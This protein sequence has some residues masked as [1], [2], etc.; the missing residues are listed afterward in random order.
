MDNKAKKKNNH[1]QKKLP[2]INNIQEKSSMGDRFTYNYLKSD[3]YRWWYTAESI[4]EVAYKLESERFAEDKRFVDL[5]KNKDDIYYMLIGFA[6]ENY[7]KGAIVQSLLVS[8]KSLEEDKLD[9]V[10]KNHNISK[11]FSDAGLKLKN[12]G[13]NYALD[14]ISE[15]IQWRG[16]YP[17]PTE[18]KHIDGSIIYS[19][20]E[21]GGDWSIVGFKNPIPIDVIHEFVEMAKLNLEHIKEKVEA[22]K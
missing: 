9:N 4:V 17:L 20:T 8:G 21:K 5:N 22:K 19:G 15:C 10:L 16:R 12:K 18:A 3:W 1:I 13:Y 7:L 14:Y 6:L 2:K 11:L